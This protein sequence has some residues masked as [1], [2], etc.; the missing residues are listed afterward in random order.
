MDAGIKI[1]GAVTARQALV[2]AAAVL[3]RAGIGSARL[4]AEVLLA[5]ALGCA[6]ARLLLEYD[7]PLDPRLLERF[8]ALLARRGAGEPVAYIAGRKEFW[9]LDFAVKPAVL[10]PRPETELL[11]ETA[12][13]LVA[14]MSRPRILDLGAG[15]GAIA[16]CLAKET[17]G[18]EIYA[19]D[20]SLDALA[21]ARENARRN[22]VDEQIH[23]AAGDLFAPV[24]ERRN[25]F[26]LIVSNPPYIRTGDLASLPRDVRDFEPRAALDGGPDGLD[27]Y[28]RIIKGAPRRLAAGGFVLLE[29]GADM[30]EAVTRLFAGRGVYAPARIYKDLARKDRVVGARLNNSSFDKAQDER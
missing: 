4:D 28:R 11:V 13:G 30:G 27:F 12:L 21:V 6:A 1:D 17:P 3:S 16:V 18:A 15:S 7:R 14:A 25:F 5:E 2:E 22:G 10:V 23:F 24:D 29:I 8:H 19:T 9:S 26:D 20:I